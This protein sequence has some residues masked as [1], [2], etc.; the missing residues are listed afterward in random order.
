VEKEEIGKMRILES[1]RTKILK[2][3]CHSKACVN[4]DYEVFG[5]LPTSLNR[6]E[7]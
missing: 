2:L 7:D 5:H 1:H 4:E 6:T 3:V